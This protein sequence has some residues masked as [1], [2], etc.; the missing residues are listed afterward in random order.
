M[1]LYS[2]L[3]YLKLIVYLIFFL[4]FVSHLLVWLGGF[5]EKS[6]RSLPDFMKS[7]FIRVPFQTGIIRIGIYRWFSH[8]LIFISFIWFLFFYWFPDVIGF[9]NIKGK[10]SFF[11]H[12][13]F[14]GTFL[15]GFTI[16]FVRRSF[17]RPDVRGEFEDFYSLFILFL[18]WVSGFLLEVAKLQGI[19]KGSR[20]PYFFLGKNL[21]DL[22]ER[23]N[24]ILPFIPLLYIHVILVLILV[25]SIP[26]TKLSHL[27]T[28]PI[29]ELLYGENR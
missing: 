11:L 9:L 20:S 29:K 21:A 1:K 7:L 25:A 22:F 24:F 19:E 28:I 13:I 4:G 14:A 12:D 17:S 15:F 23:I 3:P 27:F 2:L 8:F 6:G 16:A 5:I 18:V 10:L 26:W